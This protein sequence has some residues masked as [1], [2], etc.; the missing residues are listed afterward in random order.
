MYNSI[1]AYGSLHNFFPGVV[2]IGNALGVT[3]IIRIQK[4][5]LD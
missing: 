3:A 4:F 5:E 2:K 1:A